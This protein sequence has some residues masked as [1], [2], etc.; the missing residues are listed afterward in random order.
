[1]VTEWRFGFRFGLGL[2]G[3]VGRKF[4]SRNRVGGGEGKKGCDELKGIR[5]QETPA[6]K[7]FEMKKRI[8]MSMCEREHQR[9]ETEL[10]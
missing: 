10:K 5:E 2:D 8:E 3:F 6:K 4:G 1:M 7:K 9:T